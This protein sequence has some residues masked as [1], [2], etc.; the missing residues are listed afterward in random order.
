MDR[1]GARHHRIEDGHARQEPAEVGKRGTLSAV[2]RIDEHAPVAGG[3][4]VLEQLPR[5]FAEQLRG[6][7]PQLFKD[8]EVFVVVLD[9]GSGT[10]RLIKLG[11]HPQGRP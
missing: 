7:H 11:A 2:T 8:E 9:D 3:G 5:D 4:Q 6:V 1:C 10:S